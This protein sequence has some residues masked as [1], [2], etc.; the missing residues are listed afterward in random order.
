MKLSEAVMEG[1]TA[2]P[3]SVVAVATMQVITVTD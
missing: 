1:I 2:Q 3:D